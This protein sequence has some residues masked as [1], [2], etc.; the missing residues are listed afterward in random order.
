MVT[1]ADISI[2]FD[3][4]YARYLLTL[5]HSLTHSLTHLHATSRSVT[6]DYNGS[7]NATLISNTKRLYNSLLKAG[8]HKISMSYVAAHSGTQ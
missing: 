6:G 7:A 4:E 5:T 2:R 3:S 1:E 8:N